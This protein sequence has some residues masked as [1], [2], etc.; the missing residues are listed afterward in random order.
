VPALVT[1]AG[2]RARIRFLEF[3]G[4]NIRNPHTRRAYYRAADERDACSSFRVGRRGISQLEGLD[5][6]R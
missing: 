4:A 1:A 5:P 2:E 3:F 6:P